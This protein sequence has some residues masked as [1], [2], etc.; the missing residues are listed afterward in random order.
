MKK[1]LTRLF[2]VFAYTVLLFLATN[3]VAQTVSIT[4]VDPG[5]Y[6]PG[7]SI[8][9]QIALN[10]S[11][12]CLQKTNKFNLYLS[13]ALGSFANQT[14]IGSYNGFGTNG[15]YATFI[16]GVIPNVIAGVGY[17]VRVEN[18]RTGLNK[19]AFGSIYNWRNAGCGGLCFIYSN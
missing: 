17:Q 18:H 15:T 12:G 9:V 4:G 2:K 13:D 1:C 11:S 8:A 6:G 3:S 16:N 10:N 14:L 7:S 5:P 19:R